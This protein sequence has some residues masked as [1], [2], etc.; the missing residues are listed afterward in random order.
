MQRRCAV[1]APG[2]DFRF[3]KRQQLHHI[4]VAVNRCHVLW[5]RAFVVFAETISGFVLSSAL[6][7]F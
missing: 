7:F 6:A 1:Y 4:S 3:E 5:C 2:I